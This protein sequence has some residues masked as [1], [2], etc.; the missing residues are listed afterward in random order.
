MYKVTIEEVIGEIRR[1]SVLE[2]DDVELV[3]LVLKTQSV[4]EVD[5]DIP[6]LNID[7]EWQELM[8]WYRQQKD[9]EEPTTD[10]YEDFLEQLRRIEKES[11]KR[12]PMPPFS[13]QPYV[14]PFTTPYDPSNP[15]I[16]KC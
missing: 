11:T 12:S 1:I 5:S 7:P 3:K 14:S 9:K 16:V 15:F 8:E 13:P 10:V 4:I 6:N 2:T